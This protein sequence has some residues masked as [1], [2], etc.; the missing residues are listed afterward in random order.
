MILNEDDANTH[1]YTSLVILN[2]VSVT[3]PLVSA[4]TA[5]TL[6]RRDAAGGAVNSSVADVTSLS[7]TINLCSIRGRAWFLF[8]G[9]DLLIGLLLATKD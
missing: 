4:D 8:N 6:T 3:D 2:S 7:P 5:D 1:Q 9:L